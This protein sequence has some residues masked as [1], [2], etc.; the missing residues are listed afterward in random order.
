MLQVLR[1]SAPRFAFVDTIGSIGVCRVVRFTTSHNT[2][3]EVYNKK[4][5]DG[6]WKR[7]PY[8]ET[9]VKAINRLYTELESYTQPPITQDSMPAEKGSIL[10]WISPLKKMFSRK[11]SPTLTSSLPVPGMPKGIYLY[12]DVGCGKTALMDLFYHNLPPNVTRSQRIHFH[13]FMMQVHRTS[14]DLQDRYGFE[15]DFIDHIASGIAKETTVL[16]F[17]ELQVTDVADALLLRR[18]FE[19]LMKYGVVIFITSNRAPSDLYKNGIQ[20]ESFIPCIKLLEH[21]LQVICLDS[22]NDYRRL[23]SKTEDTYLYPANSPE[24]KKA[25]ENWFFCYADEKD[26][27]HQDEVEVFGRKIIVPKAS[28]NV[29]WFTF[30]QLCGE[31][32]SA[33]DYLSLASRYHVFIVSDIPKLSIESKDLIHRF[34]TFIDAL[35]DTHGKLILSSEVPVQEIYPTAPSE[36]LSSTADLA[37]KGKIESHYHGAFGGIEEVFTFTRCLSRLSEMKKQSWIHSP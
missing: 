37:A 20:R 17:D 31:P 25:L 21:R 28:G 7:D 23:K 27:A 32:K 11:K 2:P 18:L 30:E 5:N 29:A 3:I 13:A 4:V 12:G 15:I 36:V 9:A 35:Y 24:V 6:V 26:P 10:S 14:H 16:C 33:A 19:A 22:P 34:I 8:Q 1:V